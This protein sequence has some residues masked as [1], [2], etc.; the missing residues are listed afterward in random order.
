[1]PAAVSRRRTGEPS[2]SVEL[3]HGA[4]LERRDL[5][6]L[7]ERPPDQELGGL[8]EEDERAAGV[9]QEHRRGQVRRE[10]PGEDQR[11]ALRVP[12]RARHGLTIP[13][14]EVV[15][16]VAPTHT[17]VRRD[18]ADERMPSRR[19]HRTV[20]PVKLDH[21]ETGRR[22]PTRLPWALDVVV[23]A[24]VTSFLLLAGSHIEARAHGPF[25]RC[26][27]LCPHR[28]RGIVARAVP[29]SASPGRRGDHGRARHVPA[30]ALPRRPDL[31]DRLDRPVLAELAGEPA[32]RDRRRRR[33]VLG[34]HRGGHARWR[35]GAAAP[36][37]VRRLVGGRGVPRRGAAQPA[38]ATSSRA[39]GAGPLPRAHPRGGGR[40][41]RRRGSAPDRA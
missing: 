23:A 21:E 39:R 17:D 34:A 1:M 27:R 11:E 36:P 6:E 32:N 22:D 8:V 24:G 4:E 15:S 14:A 35:S 3:E 9:D 20:D 13:R 16:C 25:A 40:S 30:A 19:T 7:R 18:C 41:P 2:G 38:R 33:H 10:L 29:A 5:A 37:R 12:W 31:R 28:R 26:L